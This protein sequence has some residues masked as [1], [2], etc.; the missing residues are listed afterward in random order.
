[1]ATF[2]TQI[3]KDTSR[4]VLV[5]ICGFELT[6]DENSPHKLA[7]NSFFGALNSNN[8]ILATHGGVEKDYYDLSL[9]RLWY[10]VSFNVEAS[11]CLTWSA[12]VQVPIFTM[13]WSGIYNEDGVWAVI[14]N[15][16]KGTA[17]CKGDI[18]LVTSGVKSG[19]Y[20][21]IAEFVKNNNDYNSGHLTE[22]GAFNAPPFG[23]TP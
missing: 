10:D 5:K 9:Y 11:A 22:P 16:A 3:I 14:P 18:G 12:D 1:M 8:Q 2:T 6:V 17:N 7:A 21:I 20:T 4:T 23:V 15:S 19:S 13:G